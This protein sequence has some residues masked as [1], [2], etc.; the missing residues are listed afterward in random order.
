MTADRTRYIH[1]T[2]KYREVA[3]YRKKVRTTSAKKFEV[4]QEKRRADI[5]L[6]NI[7]RRTCCNKIR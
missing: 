6:L 2:V 4:D 7:P 3:E 5:S 1:S